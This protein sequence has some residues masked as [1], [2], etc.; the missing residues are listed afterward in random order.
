VDNQEE[1]VDVKG[2]DELLIRRMKSKANEEICTGCLDQFEDEL[3]DLFVKHQK[4]LGTGET[5]FSIVALATKIAFIEA[6]SKEV[7]KDTVEHAVYIGQA[8]AEG[9]KGCS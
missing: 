7:A 2:K 4:R 8:E 3:I 9:E 6:P 1:V 5:V